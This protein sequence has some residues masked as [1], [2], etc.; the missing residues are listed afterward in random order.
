MLVMDVL[1]GVAE[2]VL[3]GVDC[4]ASVLLLEVSF[5]VASQG[6]C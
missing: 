5:A 6:E 1:V 2:L 4:A 3:L